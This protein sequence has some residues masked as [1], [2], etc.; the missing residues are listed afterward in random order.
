MR[1]RSTG[2]AAA[3]WE[4]SA[5]TAGRARSD[6]VLDRSEGT[7]GRVVMI[8]RGTRLRMSTRAWRIKRS[9]TDRTFADSWVARCLIWLD[10]IRRRA[11]SSAARIS[12][13]KMS[14]K[15]ARLVVPASAALVASSWF[16]SLRRSAPSNARSIR[17]RGGDDRRSRMPSRSCHHA[18]HSSHVSQARGRYDG[19]RRRSSQRLHSPEPARARRGRYIGSDH[20]RNRGE[21]RR[22]GCW[23]ASR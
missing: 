22:D 13:P 6:P 7:A 8:R 2:D 14:M 5:T 12:A 10:I 18:E 11:R 23:P 17:S 19:G 20:D 1:A 16:H 4:V 21:G 15:P 3:G 9:P